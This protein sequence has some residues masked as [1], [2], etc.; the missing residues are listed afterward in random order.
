VV[1]D[2]LS[3]HAVRQAVMRMR[4]QSDASLFKL[5]AARAFGRLGQDLRTLMAQAGQRSDELQ[6]M[7]LAGQK[8][9]NAEFGFALVVAPRPAL[10]RYALEL[11]RIEEGYSRYV[12]ITQVWRLA[13]P[14][15]MDRFSQMLLSRLRVV[16]DGA[17]N[18]I[19]LWAKSASSQLDDQLRE[20]R[21]AVVQRRD[22]HER[23]RAAENGL[24]T[25]IQELQAQQTRLAQLAERVAAEV[26]KARRLATCPPVVDGAGRS[27][28]LQLVPSPSLVPSVRV[29]A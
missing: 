23:I 14:G 6:K 21:R 17:A 2:G 16:F 25:S 28:H 24:E 3:S 8:G 1:L 10:E 11:D 29:V 9:L 7:L 26:D 12:G 20:R 27:S 4:E 19:E 18:D 15:F 5:G 22:A 13:Q